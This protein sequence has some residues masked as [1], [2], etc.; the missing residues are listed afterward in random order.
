MRDS[1][2]LD[3]SDVVKLAASFVD[4]EVDIGENVRKAV[5]V[6]ARHVKDDWQEPLK[7]SPTIP[8]GPYAISYDIAGGNAVRG[9]EITAEIGP[10]VGVGGVGGLIG[11]LE[12][13]TPS[14][15]PRGFGAAALEKNQAD[16]QKGL[17]IA[18]DQAMKKEG[19]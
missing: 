12:Y 15:G 17:E 16:F 2:E 19:L 1:F 7:G 6:T 4:L 18:V 10:V 9:S 3:F 8:R 11:M 14:T 13:G 5:I